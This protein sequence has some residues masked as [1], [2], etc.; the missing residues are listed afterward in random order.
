MKSELKTLLVEN[1]SFKS[2]KLKIRLIEENIKKNLCEICGLNKWLDKE[3]SLDL[4]HINGN[5]RDNRLE[6][7]QILCPN[8]HRQTDNYSAKNMKNFK[9]HNITEEDLKYG[10]EKFSNWHQLLKFLDLNSNGSAGYDNIKIK[11]LPIIEKFN[12]DFPKKK[13]KSI[14]LCLDCGKKIFKKSLRCNSCNNKIPHL[15]KKTVIWPSKETLR[16]DILNNSFL[17]I[18][19]KYGVSD[20]AIRKWCKSYKLPYLKKDIKK[21]KLK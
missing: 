15:H 21:L 16:E 6:N 19:K 2:H 14:N 4:H 1:S 7:L 3:I 18:G 13:Y 8:C 12:I 10:L 5:N 9:R 17:S 11:A 20:N